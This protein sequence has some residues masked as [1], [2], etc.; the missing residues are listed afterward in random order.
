MEQAQWNIS[1]N[2][3]DDQTAAVLQPEQLPGRQKPGLIHL[4]EQASVLAKPAVPK[5]DETAL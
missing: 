5:G 4:F 3:L 2:E 1:I